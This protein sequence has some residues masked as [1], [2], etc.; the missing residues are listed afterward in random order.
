M[1]C[2]IIMQENNKMLFLHFRSNISVD[3]LTVYRKVL[4]LNKVSIG[5]QITSF[6]VK[7]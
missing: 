3:M 7:E 2:L 6:E 5:Y 4:H 1:S